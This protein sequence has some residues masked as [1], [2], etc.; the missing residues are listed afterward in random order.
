MTRNILAAVGG[1]I[2][3]FVIIL[4]VRA[5]GYMFFPPMVQLD[6]III[7]PKMFAV[8]FAGNAL[9]SLVAGYLIGRVA[10]GSAMLIAALVGSVFTIFWIVNLI[11]QPLPLWV[12]VTGCF[13]FIPFAAAGARMSGKTAGYVEE[14][15]VAVISEEE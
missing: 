5:I 9:G 1:V 10:T 7:S 11:A 14:D 4:V 12:A 6:V 13:T 2:V 8:L 3:T 15:D